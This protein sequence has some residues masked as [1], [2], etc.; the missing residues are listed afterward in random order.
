VEAYRLKSMEFRRERE[1]SWHELEG[2]V[3]KVEKRGLHSL[4]E[5]D[6][7]RL[8]VLYRAAVSSLSVARSI[9][10]DRNLLDYLEALC[11]RAYFAVYGT[12]RHVLELVR[13]FVWWRFP[14]AVRGYAGFVLVSG[15]IVLLGALAGLAL[16]LDDPERFYSFVGEQYAQGRDP[17][18]STE[19]LRETL[20][21]ESGVGP[22]RLGAFA[23][24]LFSNNARIG[25]FSFALGFAAGLPVFVL[26][27]TNGLL[28]GA[29]AA[30]F[31]SRGLAVD[32]WGWVLPHGVTELLALVLCGA[33]GL[34]L[35]QSLLVPGRFTRLQNL[36]R[37][38]REAG[39][40]VLGA[41]FMFFVAAVIEG[42]FRQ[43]VHDLNVRWSVVGVTV[44]AWLAYFLY[45]GRG[46]GA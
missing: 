23:S 4:T 27:F 39:V 21:D 6:L 32:F 10:L 37:R 5:Q 7:S 28:L 13:E 8:P 1:S 24:F 9:S 25:M 3:E 17:S 42:W 36:A 34:V 2:L 41:V 18:A 40:L 44:V 33:A 19:E 11:G 22:E 29:F 45:A 20:Y 46:R 12:R 35:G 43:L 14:Q 15:G 26:L 31:H 16:T 30:L 38:G